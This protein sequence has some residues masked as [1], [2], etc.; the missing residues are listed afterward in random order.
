M[1]LLIARRNVKEKSYGPKVEFKFRNLSGVPLLSDLERSC[2][3]FYQ[4]QDDEKF[5][6]AK[7][8]P[9]KFEWKHYDHN[10]EIIEKKKKGKSITLKLS[11][12]DLRKGP[13]FMKDGD[14]IG[15]RFESENIDGDDDF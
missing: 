14:I 13:F 10:E 11:E 12:Q 15:L 9:H 3:E 7:Y 6:I 4:I 1:I 5:S 8:F 2:K